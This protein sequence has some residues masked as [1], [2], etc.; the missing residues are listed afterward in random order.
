[1]QKSELVLAEFMKP[2]LHLRRTGLFRRLSGVPLTMPVRSKQT[3]YVVYA[4]LFR[5]FAFVAR[6]EYEIEEWRSFV[7]LLHHFRPKVFW[8]VGANIGLY[9]LF[10]L[11]RRPTGSVLAFEP[12]LRNLRLF[13]RTVHR[14]AL[15]SV[16]IVPKAVDRQVG[17][18]TFFLDDITGASGTIVPNNFFISDQYGASPMQVRVKTTTLD[19]Q[20]RE[21]E[22]P[23][24]IK[25]DIEGAELSALE[26]GCSMLER[27]LPVVLY[28]A[29]IN[30]SQT[31]SLLKNF[32]Y[33]LFNARTLQSIDDPAYTTI[34]LHQQK[35]LG[36]R[37]TLI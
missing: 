18:T 32:G 27:H 10:F 19:E 35:H 2:L 16:K 21:N 28:E 14:N 23:D 12:D 11:S 15:S 4:D 24:L 31:A 20:L 25:I 9:S 3:G 37:H 1:M 30:P 13:N 7:Q 36:G 22:G 26:G 34:A 6:R 5:N 8:D 33:K 29:S 17:E